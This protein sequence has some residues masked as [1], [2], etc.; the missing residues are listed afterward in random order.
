MFNWFWNFLYGI[1]K[2][3]YRIIDFLMS[4]ANML[5]GIEPIRYQGV[6]TDFLTFLL[7]NRNISY[8]FVGAALIAVILTVLFG[9]AA[10]IRAIVSEKAETT[11][12]QVLVKVGKTLLM[13]LFIPVCLSIFVYFTN[14]LMQ[15]L[16]TATLG[17]SPDGIGRFLAGA[18]GQD[19][20]KSGVPEDFYLRESFNYA[21]TGSARSY[22]D[23]TDYDYFFSWIGSICIL[24]SL[25][26]ALLSFIDR[27]I[28]IVILFIFS[29]ISISSSV[30]DD[31][32]HFKLWRDQ[33]LVK[34]LTGYG[35]IIAINIYTLVIAAIT[36][37]DLEFFGNSLLN[38]FMK[39]LIIVGGSVSMQRAMALIGNLISSGAGTNEMR[40]NAMAGMAMRNAIGGATRAL[41]AP[42]R[43]TR[44]AV[45]F[46]RDSRQFGLG[47]T[48][49]QRLGFRT[50]RDYG[51]MSSSQLAQSRDLMREREKLRRQSNAS[52]FG[53]N[54]S[55]Q[56]ALEEGG[57]GGKGGGKGGSG[58]EAK[59]QPQP[60]N[61]PIVNNAIANSM[62]KGGGNN[63]KKNSNKT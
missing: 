50:N 2:S 39:I 63:D 59:A 52:F 24:L 3:M 11:P 21:S 27:A 31:G 28:S 47:S 44:S 13:F 51:I 42:F 57:K 7:R 25:G 5:C 15:S 19:A 41:T 16:Y 29:P 33:F 4:C 26:S 49:G 38:N 58:K 22:M 61:N 34:F 9:V 35:C 37:N 18:F 60:K 20:R 10:L 23:L 6:E 62:N 53:G 1:S 8:G 56:K 12:G 43:A 54:S 46:V 14:V 36:T 48:I 30:I 55:V 40:E 17:G 45:N 32:A